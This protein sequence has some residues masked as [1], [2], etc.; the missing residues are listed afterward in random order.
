[1]FS[2]H[3]R[4]LSL[5]LW[6]TSRVS[7][8]GSICMH[9]VMLMSM[10][11]RSKMSKQMLSRIYIYGKPRVRIAFP[12]FGFGSDLP[13]RGSDSDR[14]RRARFGFGSVSPGQVRIRIGFRTVKPGSVRFRK[15]LRV[16]A[17]SSLC[18]N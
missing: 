18:I 14:F 7:T 13:L 15:G 1:M 10:V 9:N 8:Q 5:P 2:G 17:D 6:M 3:L 12:E 16:H 11:K 4:P